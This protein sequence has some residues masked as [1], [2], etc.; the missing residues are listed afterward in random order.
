MDVNLDE[1]R[2]EHT[3]PVVVARI[4]DGWVA[5]CRGI[6]GKGKTPQEAVQDMANRLSKHCETV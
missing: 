5:G 1:I 2:L 6:H 3:G 4:N